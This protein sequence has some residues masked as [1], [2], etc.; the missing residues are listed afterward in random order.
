ML[1]RVSA[2]LNG[3][4]P[5]IK[6]IITWRSHTARLIA[7]AMICY[8]AILGSRQIHV[9][10]PKYYF[11]FLFGM[12]IVGLG[13]R[14]FW[15]A[16]YRRRQPQPF[17]HAMTFLV[18]LLQQPWPYLAVLMCLVAVL[19]AMVSNVPVWDAVFAAEAAALMVPLTRL[20][21]RP[22]LRAKF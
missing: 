3:P 15:N 20:E 6:P 12:N 4:A 19:T 10:A 18:V 13:I 14:S 22:E 7:T 5:T 2:V 9:E 17:L 1:Q 16:R 11:L 8:V 21:M